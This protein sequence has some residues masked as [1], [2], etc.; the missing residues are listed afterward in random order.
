M[1][2]VPPPRS[3]SLH[4]RRSNRTLQGLVDEQRASLARL[5]SLV[6]GADQL[7]VPL[8]LLEILDTL[9]R[10]GARTAAGVAKSLP[11]RLRARQHHGDGSPA[12][13][14]TSR[15]PSLLILMTRCVGNAWRAGIFRRPGP[16]AAI[17]T[18]CG[19]AASRQSGASPFLDTGAGLVGGN[20]HAWASLLKAVLEADPLLPEA[21]VGA[22]GHDGSL[23][24]PARAA[25]VGRFIDSL[26]GGGVGAAH[27]PV[28]LRLLSFLQSIDA[29]VSGMAP[30]QLARE[31]APSLFGGGSADP[32]GGGGGQPA[33][34]AV[35][36]AR[37]RRQEFVED[38][39][40][41]Y[42]IPDG[43]RRRLAADRELMERV[44]QE[45]RI[46][47]AAE[48]GLGGTLSLLWAGG[49]GATVVSGE[50]AAEELGEELDEE[51]V[52]AAV[53]DTLVVGPDRLDYDLARHTGTA[54]AAPA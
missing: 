45:W 14:R 53:L 35:A 10:Q 7:T 38:L 3:T 32:A 28:L 6:P 16:A 40:E 24:Q 25:A 34:T 52:L 48:A 13:A 9:D 23:P 22:C 26:G 47:K 50:P 46:A 39:I 12:P 44:R 18:L 41:C 36:V 20:V 15:D 33:T 21:L 31:L 54:F 11:R 5:G 49:G 37:R 4:A 17:E 19:L 2:A 1:A 30:R 51:A 43:E 42:A 29:E 8:R 27:R